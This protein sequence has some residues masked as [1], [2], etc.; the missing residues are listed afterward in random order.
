VCTYSIDPTEANIGPDAAQG[1]VS[2]T[3]GAGCAWTAT[4][5]AQWITVASGSA[6]TGNA[7]VLLT[8]TA[9]IGAARTGTVTIATRTFTVTQRAFVPACTYSIDPTEANLS[10]PEAAQGT[11]SV[12]AGAGCAWTATSNASWITVAS[13]ASGT[14][15]GQVLLT[16]P[17]NTGAQ[18]TGTVTIATR[19]FTLTQAAAVG[20]SSETG[21]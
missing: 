14:G 7:Q 17:A 3:A 5:N 13:G 21:P 19:T 8:L 9:N 6:G 1:T 18:R 12:T 4:S 10:R 16:F 11:V 15:N 20:T 2:V